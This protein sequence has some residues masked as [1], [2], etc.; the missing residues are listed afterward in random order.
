MH[1][2]L[3]ATTPRETVLTALDRFTSSYAI[4]LSLVAVAVLALV[5]HQIGA[6]ALVL[7]AI[8]AFVRTAIASG[9]RVWERLFSW[10]T[11]PVFLAVVLGLLAGGAKAVDSAPWLAVVAGVVTVLMGVSAC[12][13]YM[14][15][16]VERYEVERGYKAIH[17]PLKGQLLASNLVRHGRRVG[18]PLL[19]AAAVA[20]VGG[21]AL[22]NLG[23]YATVGSSW[24]AVGED[25]AAPEFADFLVFALVHLY[26]LVDMLNLSVSQNLLLFTIVRPTLWPAN[27]L[28]GAYKTFFTLVL[29]QQLFASIRQSRA[30]AESIADF[31]SP[32]PPIHERARN[33][34]P[35]Y[36]VGVVGPLLDS[37]RTVPVLTKELRDQLP[38]V[39][40]GIGPGAIPTLVDY[41]ADPDEG[42]RGVSVAALGLLGAV[43]AL[44]A[45]SALTTDSSDLVRLEAVRALGAIGDTGLRAADR[46]A[47]V[48]RAPVRPRRWPFKRRAAVHS[49]RDRGELVVSALRAALGDTNAG[50]RGAAARS[51]GQVGPVAA[52]T[53]LDLV[54]RMRDD[55]ETVR[56]AAA[57]A[58]G[59]IGDPAGLQPLADALAHPNATVRA[60]SARALG[61]YGGRARSAVPAL[62]PLLKDTDEGVRHAASDAIR[63][64]GALPKAATEA[65]VEGLENPD[66]HVQVQTAEALGKIGETA[67]AAAPALVS[68]LQNGS[69]LVRAK[70]AEAL[71]KIGE[72]AAEAAVPT[73]IRALRDDDGW[74]SAVAAEALGE[75]GEAAEEAV[76]A[77]VRSL[78]HISPLVRA[79]AAEALGKLGSAA[80]QAVPA[81]EHAAG[82]TD[83]GVR[84]QAMRAVGAVVTGPGAEPLLLAGLHDPEP[85]VRAAAAE[86]FG[87]RG[88]PHAGAIAE[89]WRLLGDANDRVKH[90]VIGA[91]VRLAGPMPE[92]VD[93]LCR[94]VLEDDSAWVR[95]TAARNL[96]ALG[97][98][99]AGAGPALLRAARTAEEAVREEAVRAIV[100]IRPP[101]LEEVLIVGTTDPSPAVRKVATAGWM[102][103]E[104]VPETAVAVLVDALR[105]P[106]VQVRA[107][108]AHA[109]GRLDEL[110]PEAVPAL[111]ECAAHPSDGLRL[112]ATVALRKAPNARAVFHGLLDD[113]N[114][115]VRLVAAGAVLERTPDDKRAAPVV[116]A[117]LSDPVLRLRQVALEVLAALDDR[118]ESFR[119]ALLA[120]AAEE[121]DPDLRAGVGALLA[122]FEPVGVAE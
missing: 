82:D 74:V 15:I 38:A 24:Y 72:T 115:R 53:T 102:K 44:P 25:N 120:R 85:R 87:T 68:A 110:P 46:Q 59:A 50:V 62:V 16:D 106:E 37:L 116:L 5:L 10:A 109:L 6:I 108:A 56:C 83:G 3:A 9:F 18:V 114:A 63:R 65:L 105:D 35:Q 92:V 1:E 36:G 7:R 47:R 118:A 71:G 103:A 49:A 122:R 95:E 30:L 80:E 86:A 42:V 61:A 58:V 70:A 96:G 67:A 28:L 26:R 90:A 81:L 97:P 93:G 99:A 88:T 100:L 98:P 31:W 21:F 12:L 76:P 107:N 22:L 52:P 55:D 13:A 17:N 64:A 20:A 2:L 113:P 84:A 34:L 8:G 89:L 14:A 45:V 11:W 91:L 60:A 66:T 32:H 43:D 40:A 4:L 119:D 33:A 73:L 79:N 51:L 104:T 77:L 29:L 111:A 54:E 39:L 75:M 101:E 94:R 117:A 57:E 19:A 23:L 27:V 69:D 48:A 78:R 112:N 41:L 121:P